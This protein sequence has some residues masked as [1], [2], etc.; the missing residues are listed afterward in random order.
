MAEEGKREVHDKGKQK[1]KGQPPT[2]AHEGK[3]MLRK[4]IC[5]CDKQPAMRYQLNSDLQK[6]WIAGNPCLSQLGGSIIIRRLNHIIFG[7]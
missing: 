4:Y 7:I 3:R 2:S 6:A 1:I 5:P